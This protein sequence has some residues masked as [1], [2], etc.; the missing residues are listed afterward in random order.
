[1]QT[2]SLWCGAVRVIVSPA[3]DAATNMA[4]DEALLRDAAE[5]RSTLVRLYEWDRPSVSFGRHQRCAGVYSA[6][7]SEARGIPAVRRMTGGRALLHGRE[8][9]YA[10]AAPTSAAPTLRGGY[11]AI[12]A[13][14]LA[15]MQ[16]LGIPAALATPER[17]PASPGLA[18]CF[19][20]PSA[21]EIVVAT[22]K[23]IGSAQRREAHAFLQHGSILLDDDQA[24]LRELATVPLPPIPAPA[25]VRGLLGEVDAAVVTQ[26][27][28]DAVRNVATGDIVV[29]SDETLLS[30]D[31][32]PLRDRFCDPGWT[33][34]K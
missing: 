28:V 23:L 7:R 1:M 15:A 6:E 12:N 24:M 14:L 17:R 16:T 3:R 26:A 21:G 9:T 33:W 5:Q 2:A 8:L 25:T 4:L 29:T 34:R 10:V 13:V 18:P 27:I 31:I 20:M 19:E 22:Q 32:A 30:S 11:D